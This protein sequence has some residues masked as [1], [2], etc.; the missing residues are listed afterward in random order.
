VLFEPEPPDL[1][2]LPF[3]SDLLPVEPL[4]FEASLSLL[5]PALLVVAIIYIIYNDL[6]IPTTG[7]FMPHSAYSAG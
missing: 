6:F 3:E 7:K 5:L 1:D 4:F 2:A